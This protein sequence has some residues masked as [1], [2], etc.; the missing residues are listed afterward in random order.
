MPTPKSSTAAILEARAT[1]KAVHTQLQS[2][3][4]PTLSPKESRRLLPIRELAKPLIPQSLE[5]AKT[6]PHLLPAGQTPQSF[7]EVSQ[8]VAALQ[9]LALI[10]SGLAR[11]VEDTIRQLER[12]LYKTMLCIYQVAERSGGD[13]V[14]LT[15]AVEA[16]KALA[17]GPRSP[18]KVVR[19]VARPE[20]D[21]AH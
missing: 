2:L 13:P 10:T 19:S 3:M 9:Q 14:A 20:S 6:N 4:L 12:D 16:K 8:R 1:L 21:E 17:L 15:F 18:R 7:N 11:Q 5:V